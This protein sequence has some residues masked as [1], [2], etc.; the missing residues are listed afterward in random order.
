MSNILAG[1]GGAAAFFLL[2]GQIGDD[3]F[4]T[5]IAE[6]R[7]ACAMVA[8]GHWPEEVAEGYDCPKRIAQTER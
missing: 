7:E 3:D 6:E 2:L 4:R 8:A 1:I 5:E